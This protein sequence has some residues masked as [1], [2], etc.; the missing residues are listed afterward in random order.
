MLHCTNCMDLFAQVMD[1]CTTV[2]GKIML[3]ILKP[4]IIY[5]PS[6]NKVGH[7]DPTMD[8]NSTGLRTVCCDD[9]DRS[10]IAIS[11][12]R[13]GQ[14][15]AAGMARYAKH[16]GTREPAISS[17]SGRDVLQQYTASDSA[18]RRG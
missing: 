14:G 16:R 4:A 15:G 7:G 10:Y 18:M 12:S 13:R 8:V 5:Y 3:R 2:P 9:A 17:L 11:Q 6:A 1:L